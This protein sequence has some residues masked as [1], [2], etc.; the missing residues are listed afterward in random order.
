VLLERLTD[1]L[2]YHGP[3]DWPSM[4]GWLAARAIPGVEHVEV[5]TY[6]RTLWVGSAHAIVHARHRPE[7]GGFELTVTSAREVDLRAVAA[8]MT[9]VLDLERDLPA[10]SAHLG[11]DP[12][13]ATLLARHRGVRVPG[14]WEPFELATR[15]VLGQQVTIGAARQ[16]ATSLVR[17]RGSH[18]PA[19]LA[20]PDLHAV[21]PSPER[22]AEGSLDGLRMP[23]SR[24]A[25][26]QALAR[27]AEA[28]EELFDPTRPLVESVTR[29]RGVK[30]IGE[31]T[32]QYIA[33]RALRDTDA[34]PASDVGLLRGAGR[35][36]G[37]RPSPAGLLARAEAW[38][39]H[40]AYAA[41]LLWAED[42]AA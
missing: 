4:R 34:F 3:Y 27:A 42:G 26:L 18:L 1:M 32:A 14:G 38:R 22:L 11:R 30:G 12:W 41:Q 20:T 36:T 7:I 31:W 33:L 19:A 16:L 37:E 21:F 39:P 25:T 29:L 9:R 15:A 10:V 13:L 28:D 35:E 24:K 40:R 23:G 5:S 6:A 17:C 2:P 8:R